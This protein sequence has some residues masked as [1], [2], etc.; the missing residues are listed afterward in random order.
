MG[1]VNELL[2]SMCSEGT[3]IRECQCLRNYESETG[4]FFGEMHRKVIHDKD[5]CR[6]C[7]VDIYLN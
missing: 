7:A 2:L 3:C 5:R 6:R 4:K 1:W